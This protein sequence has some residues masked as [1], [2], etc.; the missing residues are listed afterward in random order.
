MNRRSFLKSVL[1]A[2]VAPAF[3]G[4]SV[5]MPVAKILSAD[6]ISFLQSGAGASPLVLWGDGVRDDTAAMQAWLDGLDVVVDRYG[7]PLGRVLF[8]GTFRIS[9]TLHMGGNQPTRELVQNT[10]L[11]PVVNNGPMIRYTPR[12]QDDILP[13][14][15]MQVF[16]I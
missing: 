5:L 8:G 16:G 2:G 14:Y 11:G 9:H 3:V 10:F 12:S 13:I 15:G 4:S 6:G 7:N 1:A